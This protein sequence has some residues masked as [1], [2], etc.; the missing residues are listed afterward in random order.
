M[1]IGKIQKREIIDE[2]KESYLDYAMSVI[3]SRA[4]PDVRDGFK[5]VHRKILYAM[6]SMGLAH[7]A[8]FRK[9]AAVVGDVIAK[10][11]PHGDVAVYDSMVRMA[12]SFSLRYPL[13]DGQGNFGSI[14][15]DNAA[16]Y[17]Y[18]EA[19]LT[20]IA[21][22]MLFDIGKDTV[23]FVDNYDG[24]RQEP[25]VLPSLLP[26]LILNG[27]V[28][29]AV[30]MATNI[31][32]HNLSEVV[33]ALIYLIDNPE[34]SLEDLMRFIKGPDFPTG[35]SIYDKKAILQA[36]ATGKGP[37]VNRAKTEIVETKKETFQI[38]IQE[39]T[40]QVNKASLIQ[41]IAELVKDKKIEHIRDVRDE[42]DRDGIRVVIELKS[43]SQPQKVLNKL[44]KYTDLQKTFHM[45]MLCLVDGIQPQVLGLK[46][47]LEKFLEYR[48]VIITR[49][50]K[51]DL[52]K[53]KQRVHILLGLS[54]AL[55][56]IDAVI[57]TIKKSKDRETAH[58][59]LKIR[60]K[61]TDEQATAI[62]E[63][64]LQTLAGL[65]R[66]KIDDELKEKQDFIE[67]LE[68]L[69]RSPKK[70]LG[71]IKNDFLNLKEKYSDNRRT[72][73]FVSPVGEFKEEEL[74]PEEEAVITL[75]QGGYIKRSSPKMFKTQKR[76]G[77]G[78][79]GITT[80]EEDVT[81]HFI[82]ASTH[83]DILFFTDSG[84]VFKTKV[85]EVP[86][87]G[88][89]ARGQALVN[90]VQISSTEKVTA[91]FTL[92]KESSSKKESDVSLPP[93]PKYLFMA[94]KNGIIK[95]VDINEFKEVRKSG[96][97]AIKL[98]KED[99]LGWVRPTFGK[100]DVILITAKGQSI[101]FKEGDSRPMGRA[102]AGVTG[103]RLKA[104]DK[105][106]AM[107]VAEEEKIK[108]KGVKLLIVTEKGFGKKTDLKFYKKQRRGGSGI[109][110]AKITKKNGDL[111]VAKIIVEEEGDLIAISKKGQVIR[112]NLK[113]I[114]N[115]GRATQGVRVMRIASG[116]GVASVMCI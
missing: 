88:R 34:P 37:I 3:I 21:E 101:R 15:G 97:I 83:D 116:D 95:K 27:A 78:I 103:I 67:Y 65:E 49:R 60:F 24:S 8:K 9:S 59:N 104:D 25:V 17:R 77:K 94:T 109:K 16:A 52:E 20:K 10:Y 29:I 68:G 26:Q 7:S 22:E 46:G 48:K 42:S 47:A 106:I 96:L 64:K 31:P 85:Y 99:I 11:H 86:E 2:M 30:G 57:E 56:N 92:K 61:F 74:V 12:Q 13:V 70:I 63:I 108:T 107:D 91:V 55:K 50:T 111:V 112:M 66:K 41:K 39:M 102:A 53:T 1:D 73:V 18:T 84:R 75:T 79:I 82:G 62:L 71:V 93:A 43:G 89:T 23:D 35:G 32:P 54:K 105:I 58:K 114:P 40:Y 19:R 90:I 98:R 115:R 113:D 14:D 33:D 28:G 76:G 81:T 69:L 110:T 38:I 4:L 100:D 44:F 6:H 51:F 72:K 5:P 36:Y 80:R 87:A 45:N